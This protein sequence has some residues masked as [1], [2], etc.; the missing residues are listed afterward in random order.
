MLLGSVTV[1]RLTITRIT[2]PLIGRRVFADLEWVC[3]VCVGQ[4]CTIPEKWVPLLVSNYSDPHL[5]LLFRKYLDQLPSGGRYR[6][7]DECLSPAPAKR[8]PRDGMRVARSPLPNKLVKEAAYLTR[9]KRRPHLENALSRYPFTSDIRRGKSIFG[10]TIM[11]GGFVTEMPKGMEDDR[12][13]GGTNETASMGLASG[14]FGCSHYRRRCKIR[15]PCCNEVFDC[16]H[17]HNDAKNS[18][19]I[20]PADRHDVPR[21]EVKKIICSMCDTEQDVQQNCIKCGVCMG[22]YFCA[23]CK[24]FDD[25]VIIPTIHPFL[26]FL[27]PFAHTVCKCISQFQIFNFRSRRDNTIAM[28]VASAELE[29]KRIFSIAI[30]ADAV[31]QSQ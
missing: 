7:S 20:K 17:C 19:E 14:N 2:Q 23:K 11:E 28:N 8:L 12:S 10:A 1:H 4:G 5:R 9:S 27:P 26:K 24:F 30:D 15:A 6:Y 31:I 22:E 13:S 18:M 29:A 3:L 16:R 25:D 21:H